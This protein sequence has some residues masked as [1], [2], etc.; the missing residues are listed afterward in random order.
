MTIDGGVFFCFASGLLDPSKSL[1]AFSAVTPVGDV[2]IVVLNTDENN[3]QPYQLQVAGQYVWLFY[4][5]CAVFACM[6][7]YI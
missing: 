5:C 3:A 6:L 7:S 1:L 4:Y 2:V